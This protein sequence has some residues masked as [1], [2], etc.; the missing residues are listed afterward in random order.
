MPAPE[1]AVC[2]QDVRDRVTGDLGTTFLLEAG[3]GTGK[4]RV[5]VDRYVKCVLDAEAG[6]GDVRTVAAITF[7][8]KAAG[9]L[10]QRVR[11]EFEARAA[12][13][14]AGSAA[15]DLIER[16]L[17]A[18]DDA[19]ISTIH[20]FAGRL[21]R[22]FPVE[23]GVDPAF[24]QLDALGSDIERGRLWEEW[25]TELAAA[26]PSEE[27]VERCRRRRVRDWLAR[28]LRVGVR[29]RRP[30]ASSP[31][32]RRASSASATTSIRRRSRRRSPT[33]PPVSDELAA[34]AGESARFLRGGL[35]RSEPTTASPP[36]SNS[37]RPASR[38][39]R[40]RP[41]ITTSWRRR[42]SP[43][44]PG[45][46]P[47]R[48]AATRAIGTRRPVARTSCR[49]ATRPRSPSSSRCATSTPST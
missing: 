16:A 27:A 9:E 24:E 37:S 32:A 45:P 8:E 30:C 33:S 47:R 5:L 7:T 48:P 26:D 41:P 22:E 4:T 20:G 31:W 3:A 6:T 36:P 11:E 40:S 25:L 29:A 1:R 43:C 18:L 42:S 35:Q 10:R 2:D 34:S 12:A 15:A 17:A 49:R 14:E 28:L 44:R 39:S 46:P 38:S 19:P 23:A 13:A 21:L